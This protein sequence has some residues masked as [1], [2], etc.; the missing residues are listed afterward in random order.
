[1]AVRAKF[2]CTSIKKNWNYGAPGTDGNPVVTLSAEYDT[3]LEDQSF[4]KSTPSGHIEIYVTNPAASDQF[5][6]GRQY[7]I[8]ITP[9]E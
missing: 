8:D 5:V 3:S 7:Y 9:A 6:L 2:R 4:A 1:M